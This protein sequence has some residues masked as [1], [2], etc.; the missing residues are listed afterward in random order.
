MELLI[1]IHAHLDHWKFKKDIGEVIARA[2]EK[3][4]KVIINNGTDIKSNRKVLDL[5]ERYDIAEAALGIYP[6]E[7]KEL[8][9]E[10]INKEIEFIEK[11]KNKIKAIGEVGLDYHWEKDDKEIKKQKILFEKFIKLA[12][13]INKPI[14]IHSRNAEQ[15]CI[16]MIESSNIKKADFHCFN[17]NKALIKRI[18]DNGYYFSIPTNIVKNKNI[19][20]IVKIASISQ[21]FTET[22]SPYLSPFEGRNEPVNIL[23]TIKKI[24]E[25]KNMDEKEVVN[26]I[27][28]NYQKVF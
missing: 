23:E 9:E 16:E 21:L 24:A 8:S 7:G 6:I 26:N 25:I 28:M 4:F 14:I 20:A 10:E 2:R 27:Y 5:M 11:N 22:D 17:G 18:A 1:D 12:E 13:K 3:G 15:D 19:K